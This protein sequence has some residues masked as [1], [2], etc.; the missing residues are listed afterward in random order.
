LVR[1]LIDNNTWLWINYGEAARPTWSPDSADILFPSQQESDRGWRLYRS[2]GLEF[3]R[4]RR[5]GGDI[6]GRVPAWLT[7]GRIVYWECPQST[8]GLYVMQQDGTNPMLLTTSEE[9][10]TP[11]PSPDSK[12][13]AFSSTR[14]GNWEVYVAEM[15]VAGSDEPESLR[16][17]DHPARDGLP[18]WSPDGQWLAF[19]SD[20]EGAWAVWVM[21]ADGSDLRKL[22][23]LGGPLEGGIAK[24]APG[25][26][27]GWSW[28][29]LA[30]GR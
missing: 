1:E 26:Q 23:V 11:A 9:D 27:H 12:R 15:A 6:P 3:D 8:C 17:T 16:L 7:D 2:W 13:I 28:E 24:V 21:R 30:W 19:V 14:D 29:S 5:H 25:D 20:R 10:T 4:V 18:F 22:F